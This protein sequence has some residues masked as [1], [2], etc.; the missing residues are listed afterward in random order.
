MHMPEA[1]VYDSGEGGSNESGIWGEFVPGV[2]PSTYH[3]TGR[4]LLL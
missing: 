1:S 4:G 2:A 3:D